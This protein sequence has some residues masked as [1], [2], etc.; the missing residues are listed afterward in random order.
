MVIENQ[1][2]SKLHLQIVTHT[3]N[4]GNYKMSLNMVIN[5]V[6][7]HRPAQHQ[8][9]FA[10]EFHNIRSKMLQR[11]HSSDYR[12]ISTCVFFLILKSMKNTAP[13]KIGKLFTN[14]TVGIVSLLWT[15]SAITDQCEINIV[16][17]SILLRKHHAAKRNKKPWT[18][19][20]DSLR[21]FS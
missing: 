11:S 20:I 2:I 13:Q 6:L 18:L 14:I 9:G 4:Q 12:V 5:M 16:S 17:I 1:V 21:N 10:I 8:G 7:P 15:I 19:L 3:Q